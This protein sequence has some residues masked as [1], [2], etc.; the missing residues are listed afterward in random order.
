MLICSLQNRLSTFLTP[1]VLQI[2]E[3]HYEGSLMYDES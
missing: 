2:Y 1:N 3:T